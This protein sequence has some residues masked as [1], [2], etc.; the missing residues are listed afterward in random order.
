MSNSMK[1]TL[2]G[3][4]IAAAVALSAGIAAA[5][6]CGDFNNNGSVDLGDVAICTACAGGT[7][8]TTISPGPLCGTGA[9]NDACADV[10][11]DNDFSGPELSVDCTILGRE[12]AGLETVWGLCHGPAGAP[13]VAGCP[14]VTTLGSLL[15]ST[16]INTSRTIPTGCTVE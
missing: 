11:D 5:Q 12:A 4:V 10:F 13:N 8:P 2:V 1:P 15:G 6:N 14:G 3:L 9:L 16:T 7:C